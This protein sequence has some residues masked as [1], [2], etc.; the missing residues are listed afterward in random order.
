MDFYCGHSNKNSDP[1]YER[2]GKPNYLHKP[3]YIFGQL[4]SQSSSEKIVRN[5][6]TKS[7][8]DIPSSLYNLVLDGLYGG[9]G[10]LVRIMVLM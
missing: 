8:Q 3:K 2:R 9:W 1:Y 6:R 5:F 7:K 10:R 4:S